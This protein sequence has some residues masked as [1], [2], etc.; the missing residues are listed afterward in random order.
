MTAAVVAIADTPKMKRKAAK[1]VRQFYVESRTLPSK[2][3]ARFGRQPS[4][5]TRTGEMYRRLSSARDHVALLEAYPIPVG[6]F[7]RG[8]EYRVRRTD[9]KVS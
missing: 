2:L 1:R 9:S 6:L 5:W 4:E 7:T 8:T 3:G